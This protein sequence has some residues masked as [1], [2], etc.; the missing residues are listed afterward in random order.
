[1]P[2]LAPS[3]TYQ[4]NLCPR[5]SPLS[6][7]PTKHRALQLS[8]LRVLDVRLTSFHLEAATEPLLSVEV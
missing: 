2:G 3:I 5:K 8:F 1:M 6:H 4:A 7:Q